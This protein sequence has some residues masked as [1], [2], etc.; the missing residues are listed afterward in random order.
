MCLSRQSRH[1]P[2]RDDAL[3]PLT[4]RYSNR[5]NHLILGKNCVDGHLLLKQVQCKVHLV[6]DASTVHLDF[7]EVSLLLPHALDLASLRVGDGTD[8]LALFFQKLDVSIEGS[9]VISDLFGVL[10]ERLGTVA[11]LLDAIPAVAR[12]SESVVTTTTNNTN[13][14]GNDRNKRFCLPLPALPVFVESTLEVLAQVLRPDGLQ[15]LAALA[16]GYVSH[17]SHN[18]HRG[19]LDDRHGLHCLLLMQLGPGLVDITH[20]MRHTRLESAKGGQMASLAA[21]VLRERLDLSSK[22]LGAL[23]REEGQRTA[24]RVLKLTMRHGRGCESWRIEQGKRG[25]E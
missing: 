20:D 15:R 11:L 2:A 8:D 7:H 13:N 6:W 14:H 3:C 4:R 19:G 21:I 5:V 12:A 23:L 17:H 10:G 16:C 9:L 18:N 1:S 24:S 22:A 25:G